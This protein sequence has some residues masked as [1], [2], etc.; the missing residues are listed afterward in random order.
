MLVIR[1]KQSEEVLI[2]VPPSDKPTT[3]VLKAV[4]CN[5]RTTLFGFDGPRS[6]LILRKE[7]TK[8]RSM[9]CGQSTS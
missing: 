4:E 8:P 5:Q 3:L 9:E 7:L 6:V 1:R 2:T